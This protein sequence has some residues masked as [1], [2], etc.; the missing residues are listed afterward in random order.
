MGTRSASG[1]PASAPVPDCPQDPALRYVLAVGAVSAGLFLA[2]TGHDGDIDVSPTG[3]SAEPVVCDARARAVAHSWGI[4]P[5]GEPGQS[6]GPGT[7]VVLV[8]GLGLE[9]LRQRRGH[10]PTL[11]RWLA[12]RETAP[13]GTGA[14][15]LT[16]RPSTTAAALT[17]L[18]TSALP[19]TT[20][21]VGYSVLNPRLGPALGPSAVPGPDQVL[22]LITWKGD[23]VPSPRSW[24]DVPT[25]FERLPAGSAVSIGPTRFAGSGLTEAAL[26]G[27][28]HLGADRLEDRPG[29]AAGALRRGTPLVYLY[30]GELDK[31][32]HKH[33]WLSEQWL[34]QLE[35]LDAAMA[36]LVRRVPAGTRILLSADHGMVDT[37]P[38]HRI[39]LSA[40]RELVR[41]VVAVA[42]EPR[43]TH[44]HVACDADLAAE[45]A[46][47]YRHVLG[48]RAMWI[49]TREQTGEHLGALGA[50]ARGV[51]GDVVVAMAENWVLVDPRVHSESAIAMPGV[52]GS[53]TPAETE[54]PLLITEA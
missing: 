30:V 47:R 34:A 54:V 24:Q 41:D 20:G 8:D 23:N 50:R 32:G 17:M 21:M 4:E 27:A 48:E 9:M 42:G 49:G 2:D 38:D 14:G 45:V 3:E 43:L 18:G 37:D 36:E 19:G 35:R 22:S 39:D 15:I 52:H 28:S 6:G 10:T 44:L 33:G 25:I 13:V 46:Q 7:V 26:R 29:L 11:R 16:C 1:Q 40:H 31:T 5:A 12:Q 51:V 53:F